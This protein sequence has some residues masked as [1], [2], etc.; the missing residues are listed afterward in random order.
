MV[1]AELKEKIVAKFKE[2]LEKRNKKLLSVKDVTKAL[3]DE[4]R[5]EIK[6]AIKELVAEDKIAYWS[7]G[8]TTYLR[9]FDVTIGEE[10]A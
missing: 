6:T 7:S 5:R 2:S 3:A 8:S 4:D 10:G 1:E 9:L